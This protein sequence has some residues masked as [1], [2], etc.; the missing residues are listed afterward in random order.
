MRNK[1]QTVVLI[2]LGL[3]TASCGGA[4]IGSVG[5]GSGPF[6]EFPGADDDGPPTSK[7]PSRPTNLVIQLDSIWNTPIDYVSVIAGTRLLPHPEMRTGVHFEWG[8]EEIRLEHDL[9][10]SLSLGSYYRNSAAT[11][12]HPLALGTRHGVFLLNP[13]GLRVGLALFAELIHPDMLKTHDN[14]QF[15]NWF[16]GGTLNMGYHWR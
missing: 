10:G 6:P 15:G 9:T 1:I 5:L 13:N 7:E 8:W 11:A 2:C 3:L 4:V 12:V 16:L 14:N